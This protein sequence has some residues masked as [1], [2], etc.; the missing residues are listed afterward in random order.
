MW[1]YNIK[2]LEINM[3]E[4][5]AERNHRIQTKHI[6]KSLKDAPRKE[7]EEVMSRIIKSNKGINQNQID[8]LW[9]EFDK[10][11][12]TYLKNESGAFDIPPNRGKMAL[13]FQ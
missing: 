3:E 9:Q 7:A 5:K 8:Y 6:L 2:Q 4:I 13:D 1:Y 12:Y 10:K 11:F